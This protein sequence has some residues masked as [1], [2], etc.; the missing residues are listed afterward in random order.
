MSIDPHDAAANDDKRERAAEIRR[1]VRAA[2]REL[3]AD[4]RAALRAD[5]RALSNDL[6]KELRTASGPDLQK[7]SAELHALGRM[8]DDFAGAYLNARFPF[9]KPTDRWG[10]R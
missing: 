6:A 8:L 1:E 10:R 3:Q 7:I 9:G 2:L 4:L 5:V